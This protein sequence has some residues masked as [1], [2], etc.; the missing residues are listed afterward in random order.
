MGEKSGTCGGGEPQVGTRTGNRWEPE[1]LGHAL[2]FLGLLTWTLYTPLT[3]THALVIGSFLQHV[4]RATFI[5]QW[6]LGMHVTS[7]EGSA[8]WWEGEPFAVSTPFAMKV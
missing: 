5:L 8:D 2:K 1:L 7:L 3:P 6:A 4:L